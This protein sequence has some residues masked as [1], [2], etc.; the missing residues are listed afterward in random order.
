ME[1]E[2]SLKDKKYYECDFEF[3]GGE[4]PM[5]MIVSEKEYGEPQDDDVTFYYKQEDIKT[6]YQKLIRDFENMTT[7]KDKKEEFRK[8]INKRFGVKE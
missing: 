7:W 8:I 3:F 2:W 1:D 6:L 4:P 5:T